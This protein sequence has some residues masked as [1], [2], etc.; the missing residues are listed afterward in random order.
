MTNARRTEIKREIMEACGGESI[1]ASINK[2]HKVLGIRTETLEEFLSGMEYWKRG[3][4][5]FY[6]ISD[7]AGRITFNMEC[8]LIQGY[9]YRRVRKPDWKGMS[10][11]QITNELIKCCE[12]YHSEFY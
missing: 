8:S 2:L 6:F 9:N 12:D 10:Y 7:V 1:F 3:N 11:P 5:K 4:R